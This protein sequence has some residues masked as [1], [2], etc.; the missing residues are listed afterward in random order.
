MACEQL[1]NEIWWKDVAKKKKQ[2]KHKIEISI[3]PNPL[4][5][6]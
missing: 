3:K 1:A 5:M 4:M 2:N 6:I